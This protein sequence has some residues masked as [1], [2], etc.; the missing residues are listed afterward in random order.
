MTNQGLPVTGQAGLTGDGMQIV[1]TKYN[2][3]A[4]FLPM[5]IR[6]K[7]FLIF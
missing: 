2:V 6:V 3:M 4:K 7:Q 1:K 5:Q